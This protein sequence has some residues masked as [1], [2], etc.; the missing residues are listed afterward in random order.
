MALFPV[1]FFLAMSLFQYIT[2]AVILRNVIFN[3]T[4]LLLG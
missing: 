4:L 1:I 2:Q 3:L